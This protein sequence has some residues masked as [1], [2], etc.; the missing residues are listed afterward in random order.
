MQELEK[1]GPLRMLIQFGPV[2][3][4]R[5]LTGK[6]AQ[7]P[8]NSGLLVGKM[9]QTRKARRS[10]PKTGSWRGFTNHNLCSLSSIASFRA[11]DKAQLLC[12]RR[13]VRTRRSLT[14]RRGSK[15]ERR[16]LRLVLDSIDRTYGSVLLDGNLFFRLCCSLPA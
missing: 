1:D 7:I 2:G 15:F 14:T 12:D 6:E 16:L 3:A 4:R 11:G 13:H 9:R 8:A 5:I 10:I